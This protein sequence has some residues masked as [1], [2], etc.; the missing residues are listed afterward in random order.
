MGFSPGFL[1]QLRRRTSL[2][3]LARRRGIKLMP[4][5]GEFAALCPFHREKT[6]SF[7]IIDQKRFFHCFGCGA[8]GDAIEFVMRV[9]NIDFAALSR[10]SR[11]SSGWRCRWQHRVVRRQHRI[12]PQQ[13]MN[14][15]HL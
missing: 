11:A 10:T 4:R 6:P 13:I 15:L 12:R 9:D 8:H 7:Y 1:E 2:S 5:R 3:E 14:A